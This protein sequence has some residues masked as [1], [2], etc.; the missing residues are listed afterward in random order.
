MEISIIKIGNSK[1][2][3]LKKSILDRYDIK[4]KVELILERGR[5]ILKPVS[6]P[7]EGWEDAFKEMN[8]NEEDILFIPDVF[9]EDIDEE[10]N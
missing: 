4:D 3:R 2:I 6:K 7:R 8:D 10:W 9:E 5:I 1:G